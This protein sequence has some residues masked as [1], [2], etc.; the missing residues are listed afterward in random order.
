MNQLYVYIYP[1]EC[2]L[3]LKKMHFESSMFERQEAAVL[4]ETL[5]YVLIHTQP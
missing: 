3:I 5:C 1:I 2:R 4:G